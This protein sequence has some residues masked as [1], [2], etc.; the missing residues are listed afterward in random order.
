[1]KG[2]KTKPAQH[3]EE[4]YDHRPPYKTVWELHD[5]FV[6]VVLK[7]IVCGYRCNVM[8]SKLATPTGQ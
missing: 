8:K 1:M 6:K 4:C 7:S 2:G 5:G 3:N